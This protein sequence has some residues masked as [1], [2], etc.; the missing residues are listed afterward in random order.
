M[1]FDKYGSKREERER[2]KKRKKEEEEE[3]YGNNLTP[4]VLHMG[5]LAL[6]QTGVDDYIFAE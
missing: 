5:G 2:T 6:G 1:A 4:Q 3:E